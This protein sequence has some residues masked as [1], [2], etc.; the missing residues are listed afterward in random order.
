MADKFRILHFD[1]DPDYATDF[2]QAARRLGGI[3]LVS[4]PHGEGVADVFRAR[5]FD[6]VVLECVGDLIDGIDAF[7][8]LRG[9]K[10]DLKYVFLSDHLSNRA[11]RAALL[12]LGVPDDRRLFKGVAGEDLLKV[13]A[14]FEQQGLKPR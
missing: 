11:V 2:R 4:V 8:T 6:A 9:F 3:R 1:S 12:E 14:A 5:A 13:L 7:R 10:P